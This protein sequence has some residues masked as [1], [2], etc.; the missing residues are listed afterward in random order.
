MSVFHV[1]ESY[2]SNVVPLAKNWNE[3]MIWS[4]LQGYMGD[5]FAD[6]LERPKSAQFIL[7]D[8]CFFA[9]TPNEELI[10]HRPANSGNFIIMCGQNNEWNQKIEE[11]YSKNSK[12]VTR[13]AFKKEPDIFNKKRLLELEELLPKEYELKMIDK[14]IYHMAQEENWSSDLCSQ[15]PTAEDY[16]RRGLGVGVLYNNRLVAGASSYTIF[17]NGIEIE[18]DTK[19]EYRRKGLATAA[20]AK[21]ILE[22]LKRNLYP[23][24]DAQ[25]LWSVA[26]A[27]KLGY[28]FSHE[29]TSYEVTW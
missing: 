28:N 16:C 20:G 3:T 9:G 24:W 2:L 4:C 18:I 26:L 1:K 7:A 13:Y 23:S 8:F 12:K 6:N 10:S 19:K 17:K 21:L 25:N 15:F 14:K 29:Y 22:C 11:I 27:K 5:I